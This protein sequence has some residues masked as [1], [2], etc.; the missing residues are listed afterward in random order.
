ML[1]A[2]WSIRWS[3][4]RLVLAGFLLWAV[5]VDAGP[6]LARLQL[7]ALPDFDHTAEVLSLREQGRFG[8]SLLIADAGL[9]I[10]RE[11]GDAAAIARLEAERQATLDEQSSWVRR[12]KDAGWG[13]MTGQGDSLESLL[14]AI[15]ADL[16]VVGDVRDLLIQGTRYA[17]DGEADGV[18]LA[19][20]AAGIV[21][22][23][24]PLTELGVSIAKVA[25]R[26]GAMGARLAESIADLA[27]AG[28]RAPLQAL[29][30]DV[31][32]LARHASPGGAL[33]LM[34]HADS[35]DDLARMARFAQRGPRHAA[36]LQVTG[37][38]GLRALRSADE[39]AE[40]L[41]L[42]A[43]RKGEPGRAFLGSKSAAVLLRPHPLLGVA[44]GVYKGNA[45]AL[46]A[47]LTDWLDPRAW[48]VLP[49]L[50][51]WVFVELA[52]L[53][54]RLTPARPPVPSA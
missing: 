2:G 33:R 29:A 49:A 40:A 37:A 42:A 38:E 17:L 15:T 7:A 34:R 46:A 25:R 54:R 1:A 39:G 50:A 21:T 18:I 24:A 35:P 26:T 31:G 14:G 45:A 32:T 11:R 48:W 53:T 27:R 23:V 8:E 19:L 20:S 43:A 5:A 30:G 12:A 6:R 41:V 47:R 51:T 52:L 28:G 9:A 4:L 13:A 36:S 10:A 44:K 16:F 3:V 22:T